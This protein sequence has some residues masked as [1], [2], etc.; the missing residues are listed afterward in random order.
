MT[1]LLQALLC[2][3]N[4]PDLKVFEA[5]SIHFVEEEIWQ[6]LAQ[7]VEAEEKTLHVAELQFRLLVC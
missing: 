3:T 1:E 2:V 4:L 6:L 7:L 5:L